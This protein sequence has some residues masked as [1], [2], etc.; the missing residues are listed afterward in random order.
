MLRTDVLILGCGKEGCAAA[1]AACS[2][3]L[4]VAMMFYE[5]GRD[6]LSSLDISSAI[7]LI[8]TKPQVVL[9]EGYRVAGVRDDTTEAY[10]ARWTLD[11]TGQR[12]WLAAALKLNQGTKDSELASFHDAW[13]GEILSKTPALGQ[14]HRGPV[15]RGGFDM[16]WRLHPAAS[17]AGYFLL[18]EAAATLNAATHLQL[19]P[20]ASSG[21]LCARLMHGC[22]QG[23]ITEAEAAAAYLEHV[24]HRFYSRTASQPAIQPATLNAATVRALCRARGASSS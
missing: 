24:N 13:H 1:A 11:A 2:A 16:N 8:D 17:G 6:A 22:T 14:P 4:S 20:T 12:S 15:A 18:A 5:V 10:F 19:L 9:K 7:K 21:I 23:W 3:G